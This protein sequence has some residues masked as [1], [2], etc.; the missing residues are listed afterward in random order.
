MIDGPDGQRGEFAGGPMPPGGLEDYA[1]LLLSR[2]L[3]KAQARAGAAQPA[4]VNGVRALFV[5]LEI[6]TE[7]GPVPLSLAVYAGPG[8]G[9]FHFL[10]VSK[11]DSPPAAALGDLF[12]SFRLLGAEEAAR[13]RPRRIR[14][15]VPGQGDTVATVASLMASENPVDHFLMLNG[16]TAGRP[17]RPGEPVKIVAVAGR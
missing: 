15:V 7:Q 11:P 17:L 5:P 16:R 9:A 8:G 6:A 2:V 10:M 3:G 13:L 4:I 12:Q 14:V 1:S